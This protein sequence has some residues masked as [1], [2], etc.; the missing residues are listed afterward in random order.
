MDTEP[1][2]LFEKPEATLEQV[3]LADIR[4]WSSGGA[5]SRSAKSIAA[6][7]L[8]GVVT[9]ERLA[10]GSSYCYKVIDGS[11]R[12][13]K[14]RDQGLEVV[15]AEVLP[16]DTDRVEAAALRFMLNLGRSPNPVQEA[17]AI[18]EVFEAYRAEGVPEAEAPGAIAR[19]FGV[20]PKIV[21]QRL[22]LL[23]LPPA[24]RVG[25]AEGKVAAGVAAKIANLPAAQRDELV[26]ELAEKGK[27]TARDVQRVRQAKQAAILSELPAN[28]FAPPEGPRERARRALAGFLSEGVTADE[29]AALVRDLAE[30]TVF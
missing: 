18:R 16:E 15:N 19:R 8:R 4:P 5:K 11:R 7:G 23:T 12:L 14:A 10:P 26:G 29:L 21:G 6:L 9:L 24:L 2:P 22:R 27:L 30:R 25:V 3:A 20:S 17:E 28:L 1:T 13:N